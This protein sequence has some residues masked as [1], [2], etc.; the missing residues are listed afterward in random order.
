MK[1]VL[2]ALIF[3]VLY[4]LAYLGIQLIVEIIFSTVSAMHFMALNTGNIDYTVMASKMTSEIADKANLIT[5]TSDI[6]ALLTLFFIWLGGKKKLISAVRLRKVKIDDLIFPALLG[7]TIYLAVDGI[8]AILPIPAKVMEQ[9]SLASDVLF[10]GSI[11]I[12]LL[13][14]V[15][16]APVTEE[17]I[18][19]GLILRRLTRSM[20]PVIAA[21]ISSA[22]FGVAHMNPVWMAY[23]FCLGLALSYICLKYN[24]VL[25]SIATHMVFNLCGIIEGNLLKGLDSEVYI[26]IIL[27]VVGLSASAVIIINISKKH[28]VFNHPKPVPEACEVEKQ[29]MP[30]QD[31]T[32]ETGE[33]VLIQN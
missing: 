24:S 20:H 30:I 26:F 10:K 4:F 15:I 22:F 7:F 31:I 8:L 23:T 19:R 14:V 5:V 16:I 25:A 28:P 2:K 11:I 12:Q 6:T 33:Q 27:I 29:E 3:A 13:L 1:N 32:P 17:L 21:I 9:Y 18:C